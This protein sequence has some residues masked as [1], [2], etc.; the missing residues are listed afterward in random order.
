MEQQFLESVLTIITDTELIV[1]SQLGGD[2]ASD[3]HVVVNDE[4]AVLRG[5]GHLD[6]RRTG[7]WTLFYLAGLQMTVA[8][9]HFHLKH[10]ALLVLTVASFDGT[11]MH[12][13]NHLTKVQAY[14]CT[15]HMELAR[16]ASLIESLKDMLQIVAVQPHTIVND[17]QRGMCVI[18]DE[19]HLYSASIE[20]VFK[21]V[22]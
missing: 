18:M 17:L 5:R 7:R 3:F 20:I 16:V 10:R 9:Q 13:D 12:I 15:C 21:G 4:H 22:R 6:G 14:A 2:I 19:V 1:A 8:E 11:M